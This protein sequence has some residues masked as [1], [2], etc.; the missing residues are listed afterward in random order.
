M[1]EIPPS[2]VIGG[3]LVCSAEGGSLAFPVCSGNRWAVQINDDRGRWFDQVGPPFITPDG[4]AI[5]YTAREGGR[6]FLLRN[7]IRLEAHLDAKPDESL[8]F[9]R[10]DRFAAGPDSRV[11]YVASRGET[12]DL[13]IDRTAYPL[14][15]SERVKDLW[16]D[17]VTGAVVCLTEDSK[18]LPHIYLEGREDTN[19]QKIGAEG[20]VIMAA[21]RA[22]KAVYVVRAGPGESDFVLADG[23][24]QEWDS[25]RPVEGSESSL[26]YGGRRGNEVFRCAVDLA[27]LGSEETRLLELPEGSEQWT[28][29]RSGL[30][31][32]YLANE[33][34]KN[35]LVIQGPDFDVRDP[36]FDLVE[37]ESVILSPDTRTYAYRALDGNEL[38]VV[39]GKRGKPW[40]HVSQI[41]I[42]PAGIAAYKAERGASKFVVA[43]GKVGPA[44]EEIT[45]LGFAPDFRTVYY[46]G[47]RRDKTF[48]VVGDQATTK[49]GFDEVKLPGFSNDAKVWATRVREGDSWLV[50]VNGKRGELFPGVEPPMVSPGGGLVA[51]AAHTPSGDVLV[52]NERKREAGDWIFTFPWFS[53]DEDKLAVGVL[54]GCR[55]SWKVVE[56][57]NP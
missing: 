35:R 6:E 5:L 1:A 55:F 37:M 54:Q 38:V 26:V 46:K 45:D 53:P 23:V 8:A 44:F 10:I 28:L 32:A 41:Q 47:V 34:G 40:D 52:L 18:A 20:R 27:A 57:A 31:V 15:A 33:D 49:R 16:F 21:N 24:K 2:T 39:K 12:T 48:L 14:G 13:V 11:A 36:G 51:Y 29:D 7:H 30:N 19:Y 22:G 3:G 42:S 50:V 56:E 43:D 25:V 4:S 9:E 17:P